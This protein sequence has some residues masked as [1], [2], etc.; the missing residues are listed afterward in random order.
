MPKDSTMLTLI[1]TVHTI[2]YATMVTAVFYTLYSGITGNV[3]TWTWISI[4]LVTI[5]C[6]VFAA[7]GFHCPLTQWAQHYG[8]P[9]GY[10]GETFLPERL[11]NILLRSFAVLFLVGLG[12]VVL[13]LVQ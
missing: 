1:K 2:I 9:K 4:G 7:N 10:V 11:S 6:V 13:R 5:E 3:G 12:L 8:A